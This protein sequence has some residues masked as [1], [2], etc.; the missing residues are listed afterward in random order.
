MPVFRSRHQGDLLTVLFLHPTDDHTT[1]EL[2]DR[3]GIPLTTAHRELSRL[4]AAGLLVGRQVGRARLLRANTGHRAFG[5]LAQLLLV[6]FGPHVVITEEFTGLPRVS[7]VV[8]YGSWA[9]RYDGVDGPAPA[10]VDV[11]VVGSPERAAV[12]VAAEHAEARLAIPVNPVLRSAARWAA[13]DD[14]LVATIKTS[15][16]LVL[17]D[18][19]TDKETED[20][21]LDAAAG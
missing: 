7:H 6:T 1:T 19:T 17:T 2:A 8:L 4:E 20:G 16:H 21:A 13:G 12:Y 11:L 10:D 14:P 9:A 3:L 15:P 5:P 18:T